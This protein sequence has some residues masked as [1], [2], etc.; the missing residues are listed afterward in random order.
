MRNLFGE[1]DGS[2]KMCD[3]LVVCGFKHCS[4]ACL[5]PPFGS[6]FD[7][8]CLIIMV[9]DNLGFS[10]GDLREFFLQ[11]FGD[12]PMQNLPTTLE[13][14]IVGGLLHQSVLKNVECIWQLTTAN[15]NLSLLE[16]CE[17][18]FQF[19]FAAP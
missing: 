12:A 11:A 17:A 2:I 8:A 14:A 16:L 19:H 3:S 6:G 9:C 18:E 4:L 1:T 10:G 15:H 5:A 7:K 13:Q